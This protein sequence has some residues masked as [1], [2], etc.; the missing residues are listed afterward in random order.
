MLVVDGNALQSVDLLDLVDQPSR[1]FLFALDLEDVVRVCRTIHQWLAGAHV[2]TIL[3]G[4]MLALGDEVLLGLADLR[5]NHDL[6]FALGV[7]AEGNDA[8]DLAD[9]RVVLGLASLEELGD[10]RQTTRDVLGLGR[11]TRDLRDDL[12]GLDGLTIRGDDVSTYR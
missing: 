7:L 6:T 1:K 2:I 12:T 5:R 9:N 8:I 10:T 3:H 4:E 11:F